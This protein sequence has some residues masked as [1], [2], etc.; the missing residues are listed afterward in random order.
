MEK[1][2]IIS[3]DE[4]TKIE[5]QH[6][7]FIQELLF[8]LTSLT[9]IWCSINGRTIKKYNLESPSNEYRL[10]NLNNLKSGIYI[11]NIYNDNE[12]IQLVKLIKKYLQQSV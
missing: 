1:T 3:I 4:I 2:S 11:M 10:E 8:E 9:L 7:E 12:R 6:L 5:K